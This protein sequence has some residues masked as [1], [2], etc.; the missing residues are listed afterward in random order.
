MDVVPEMQYVNYIQLT[1]LYISNPVS[2]FAAN[3]RN[4]N[5]HGF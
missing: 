3:K 1:I 4:M 5:I 2:N